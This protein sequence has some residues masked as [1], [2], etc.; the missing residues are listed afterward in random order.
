MLRTAH[1]PV[2]RSQVKIELPTGKSASGIS[3]LRTKRAIS[4]WPVAVRWMPSVA[5]QRLRLLALPA[6]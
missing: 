4:A 3:W 1:A 6:L 5:N 2:S